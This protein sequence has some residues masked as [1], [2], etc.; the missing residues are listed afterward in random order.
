MGTH[1]RWRPPPLLLMRFS[2]SGDLT[3]D[4]ARASLDDLELL[5]DR[6]GEVV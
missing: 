5:G 6:A 1:L 2:A 3:D 4:G